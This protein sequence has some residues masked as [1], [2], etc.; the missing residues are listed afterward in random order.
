M[1]RGIFVL[2][3]LCLLASFAM[4][5]NSV[6]AA[7]EI[8]DYQ[9]N[10]NLYSPGEEINIS[11]KLF[12]SQG[13]VDSANITISLNGT[14]SSAVT[15][16]NGFFSGLII[17]PDEGSFNITL[18]YGDAEMNVGIKVSSISE[19]D[20]AII[21]SASDS[22][23]TLIFVSD[24]GSVGIIDNGTLTGSLLYSNF[25]N[26]GTTYYAITQKDSG[27]SE[28]DTLFID[29]DANFSTIKFQYLTKGSKVG[30]GNGNYD[31]FFIDPS[32]SKAFLLKTID[33]VFYGTNEDET[34]D[35]W[36]KLFVLALNS[37]GNV[38][39]DL[40]SVRLEHYN[41]FGEAENIT[42]S[43]ES[44][45]Q[46]SLSKPVSGVTYYGFTTQDLFISSTGGKHH[47]IVEGIGHISYFVEKFTLNSWVETADGAKV[48]NAQVGQQVVLKASIVD[49]DTGLATADATVS[50]VVVDP[51]GEAVSYNLE[52]DANK[53][54]AA[55]VTLDN[56][57]TGTYFVS[58]SADY[59]DTSI[60][61]DYKFNVKSYDLFMDIFSPGKGE[62]DSLPPNSVGYII[63]GGKDLSSGEFAN[64]ST[65]TNNCDDAKIYLSGMYNSKNTASQFNFSAMNLSDLFTSTNAPDWVQ[66]EIESSFGQKACAI[67][68]TTPSQT[69][70][71]R[72]EVVSNVSGEAI[73]IKDYIDVNSIFS[74]GMPSDCTT[75][76]WSES[77]QPGAQICFKVNAY[78]AI[79][80]QQIASGN[81][82][83]IN[84]IE[85][86]SQSDGVVT[87]LITNVSLKTFSD[88]SKGFTFVTSN[89]SLGP[90]FVKF[91]IKANTSI[92][93]STGAGNSWFV[94]ELWKVWA[95]PYCEGNNMFCNFGAES[96][97]S[98]KAEAFTAGFGAG[99]EDIT[100][101]VSSIKNFDTGET[102]SIDDG[103]S[104][105]TANDNSSSEQNAS[106]SQSTG[107][108]TPAYCSLTISAPEG[109]W[110]S[111]EYEVKLTATDADENSMDIYS[112]FRVENFRFWAWNRNWEITSS[113]DALFDITLQSFENQDIE[114]DVTVSKV[115]Y[116]GSKDMWMNQ[117]E[118]EMDIGV[119][120]INGS[121]TFT[122]AAG[123]F[124]GLKSGFYEIVF[125]AESD[126]GSQTSRA[127]F[128]LNSFVVFT[129]NIGDNYER[130]YEKEGNLTI[131]V[132]A[133]D[134]INWSTWP[135]SGTPHNITNISV[136]RIIKNGMWDFPY[137]A[138]G[139][140]SI[141]ESN[142]CDGL[143]GN[144][145]L[146][147]PLT[148][149]DQSQYD[150]TIEVADES[151]GTAESYF[152]FKT[153]TYTITIPEI[154]DWRT[155]P[156]SNKLTDTMEITLST[157]ASCGTT[158]DSV[159]EP[160]NVTSCLFDSN[161]RLPTIR[162][163]DGQNSDNITV[164]LLDK[165][166]T[167]TPKVYINY[168]NNTWVEGGMQ[169]HN[170]FSS[171]AAGPLSVND[172]FTDA[173]GY[174]WN[175]TEIDSGLGKI[176]LRSEVGVVVSRTNN[177]NG[178]DQ[179]ENSVEYV[180]LYIVNKSISKS[181]I[182]LYSGSSG[183]E[184]KFWDDE[185][186]SIDLDNDDK[187]N[188]PQ[189]VNDHYGYNCEE[190]FILLVDRE[191]SGVYDTLLLSPTR[192][193]S[194]GVDSYD[195]FTGDGTGDIKVDPSADAVYLLN[196]I[197]SETDGVGRYKLVTTTNKAGWAGRNLGVF[198]LGSDSIKIPVMV[199][200]PSTKLGL[201]NKT[202]VID[203]LRTFGKMNFEEYP[204]TPVIVNT[205][206]NG[207]ALLDI[208]LSTIP[209]GEYM[210]V[211][212]VD[213]NGTMV[214]SSSEWEN[215][216]L[217]LRSF[218]ISNLF[219]IKSSIDNIVEWSEDAGNLI[220][221]NSAEGS[222][223][224]SILMLQCGNNDLEGP[225]RMNLCHVDDW[226]FK[227]LWVNV[228]PGTNYTVFKDITPYDWY[229]RNSDISNETWS[230]GDEVVVTTDFGG[231]MTYTISEIDMTPE[232]QGLNPGPNELV[233]IS[234]SSC[235]F[236]ITVIGI[237]EDGNSTGSITWDVYQVCPWSSTAWPIEIGM[238]HT[239]DEPAFLWGLFNISSIGAGASNVN[240][241]KFVK[242]ITFSSPV[243]DLDSNLEDGNDGRVRVVT[244]AL[245]TEYDLYFYN[246]NS[247]KT[248]DDLEGRNS[249]SFDRMAVVNS[250]GDVVSDLP[251]GEP[252]TGV[253]EILNGKAAVQAN[254][255]NFYVYL[256]NLSIDGEYIY[257]LPW[258]C[259]EQKFYVGSFSEIDLGFNL[260]D[261]MQQPLSS[262]EN[263]IILFDS[264]CDGI[265]SITNAKFDDDNILDDSWANLGE[266]QWG[267]YDFDHAEEGEE[268]QC[269]NSNPSGNS[270]ERWMDLGRESWPLAIT[271][272]DSL[273]SGILDVFK[274][275]WNVN[276]EEN[277]TNLTL[278]VQAK[279][280]DGTLI[281]G[282]ISLS[283]LTGNSWNCGMKQEEEISVNTSDGNLT[284][285]IGYLDMDLSSLTS[286]D[287]IFKFAVQ[288]STNENKSEGI[289]KSFWYGPAEMNR[290]EGD[291]DC[292]D[293]FKG[294]TGGGSGGG[295]EMDEDA[296]AEM[297]KCQ[298]NSIIG[299]CQADKCAWLTADE[300]GS[301]EPPET[302]CVPCAMLD[303]AG[304]EIC[305]SKTGC[306]W[307]ED[308]FEGGI[309]DPAQE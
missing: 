49:L 62:G 202:V 8:I 73:A 144:C 308:S 36:A 74:Y 4:F 70:T 241:N 123:N 262:T 278:W 252:I 136:V 256:S 80:G 212:Q 162:G 101:S 63:I 235:D 301:G 150:I 275:K 287:I 228:T 239:I 32:G 304:E 121:G 194:M 12:D 242:T 82:T 22:L 72:L 130:S 155:I 213:D 131:N 226:R 206:S 87:D 294:G 60:K 149:F 69:G 288:D 111:G 61:K 303:D 65:L 295:F 112:W 182:F 233:Q 264:M 188:C 272:Y 289:T 207:I 267:A 14:I 265:S 139:K 174:L 224:S 24:K 227:E 285:G 116:M 261:C 42:N 21:S 23:K 124:T 283:K 219:G 107:K 81:I 108:V 13:A 269:D 93:E 179:S 41:S 167:T 31:V 259:D 64:L 97:I 141:G 170:N 279:N 306:Q 229:L 25:T 277:V 96:E 55:N 164:F 128:S 169:R 180:S 57:L 118:I 192:N 223:G 292:G 216:Q 90:H 29:T 305:I 209:S 165:T 86:Y 258:A 266:G 66:E 300:F 240:L 187:Y 122:I 68:F 298:A 157:D 284:N 215:P 26:N 59:A 114:A 142:D 46:V 249:N 185:W 248:R 186:A 125:N 45:A 208:D 28:Y 48:S 236:N 191:T 302:G 15:D 9:L 251:F 172:S 100:V 286:S 89:A 94:T 78:D 246:H 143:T 134:F 2:I 56:S 38:V 160:A 75:G 309:C 33:P 247:T 98:F 129:N 51:S 76:A 99:K 151:G 230:I 146:T 120:T 95:Y 47:L 291:M 54:F 268:N 184:D 140:D 253:D 163:N 39:P 231:E 210:I 119:Q 203:T 52:A 196:L 254:P 156:T 88:S 34:G 113:Q 263:Y 37:S 296:Q 276:P 200:S 176:K 117:K 190:Y 271:K 147:V 161:N 110:D 71:Y 133:F 250:S 85:V 243:A 92:G 198:Q 281:N 1:K 282:S 16:S 173:N 189:G 127:G 159:E 260:Y 17:A 103:D 270:P 154:Q 214:S 19:I 109:G 220:R 222:L 217:Q 35:E 132:S 293:S 177:A 102:I 205:S 183:W 153:E 152:W 53:Q 166:N 138:R 20:L 58:F 218:S 280:F 273:D 237:V 148:G 257:P 67:N 307:Y 40:T 299:D 244:G 84:I 245:E 199:A 145:I 211:M 44:P 106:S 274:T 181:G 43:T 168:Y 83:E 104:C 204:I 195:G 50:A 290:Q 197:Y 5:A 255:W 7:N 238:T 158:S 3:L 297:E 18:S 77:V 79:T 115:Y 193:M 225:A 11:G 175:I 221:L 201:P 27:E 137:K 30:L 232:I 135:P 6:L 10:K 171:A 178:Q 91:R 234:G 105:T 126:S